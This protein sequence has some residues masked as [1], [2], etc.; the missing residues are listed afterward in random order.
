MEHRSSPRIKVELIPSLLLLWFLFIAFALALANENTWQD[1]DVI[2]SSL[3]HARA[4][5]LEILVAIFSCA[6]AYA[7]I[8]FIVGIKRSG[9]CHNPI[10]VLLSPILIILLELVLYVFTIVNF[11]LRL[12]FIWFVFGAWSVPVYLLSIGFMIAIMIVLFSDIKL[13]WKSPRSS[14]KAW[15]QLPPRVTAIFVIMTI[16]I[17]IPVYL[18][19]LFYFPYTYV[20][21]T[22]TVGMFSR[23]ASDVDQYLVAFVTSSC[24][25]MFLAWYTGKFG[26]RGTGRKIT[27]VIG[28]GLVSAIK[29]VLI[30]AMVQEIDTSLQG[31]LPGLSAYSL[32]PFIIIAAI[33]VLLELKSAS[34]LGRLRPSLESRHQHN[35]VT[36]IDR[37]SRNKAFGM[38]LAFIVLAGTFYLAPLVVTPPNVDVQPTFEI[39]NVNG[40]PVPF[41]N[42]V[43]YPN[44]ELQPT[45]ADGGSR[46]YINL[47][48]NWR[49]S[50]SAGASD[51][52]FY[53]RTTSTV[54]RLG[55]GFESLAF[56]DSA[57][58]EMAVPSSFNRLDNPI[59][60][61]RGVQGVCWYRDWFNS[62]LLQPGFENQTVMLKCLGSNYFTDAWVDGHYAGFHEGGFTSFALDITSLLDANLTR[63]LLAIRVDSIGFKTASYF[64]KVVPGFADWFNYAGIVR[65]IYIEITPRVHVARADIRA[66]SIQPH[67]GSTH[68]ARA[69]IVVNVSAEMS[70]IIPSVN[71][72]LALHQLSFPNATVVMDERTWRHVNSS[73]PGPVITTGSTTTILTAS[74]LKSEEFAACSIAFQ[75][76]N[77]SLWT[78]KQPNLYA[79]DINLSRPGAHGII[80]RFVTQVGFRN[81]T[82][83]GSRFLLNGV[84]IFLAGASIH[85]EWA[86]SGRTLTPAQIFTDLSNMKNLSCDIFRSHYPMSPRCYLY[87]DR[88]GLSAWQECPDYWFNEVNFIEA[89]IRGSTKAMFLEM[90]YRD[91]NR[92]SIF[93]QGITNEPIS[94]RLQA[95]YALERK[96]LLASI[97]SSRIL[98]FA[99]ASPYI[100]TS[101]VTD[102]VGYNCYWG[103][104]EGVLGDYY[105]QARYAISSV[106]NSNPGK[107]IVITEFGAGN[108]K[109]NKSSTTFQEYCRAFEDNHAIC[110]MLYWVYADYVG[111]SGNVGTSGV[112]SWDRTSQRPTGLVMHE[113]YSNLTSSNP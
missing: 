9:V 81:F 92:P 35:I 64:D 38:S 79:L 33:L 23:Y 67:S 88:M 30:G 89:D 77:L 18:E 1:L 80:D 51:E 50:F 107:P 73:I 68:V 43:V 25:F 83:D 14:R 56:D 41:E 16:A 40:I 6:T 42:G 8:I 3:F 86:G 29:V 36:L 45:M 32:Y 39:R 110:G 46:S 7:V 13:L 47:T 96:A 99:V 28:F 48:G 105:N 97:D 53:P 34:I 101:V 87:A 111:Y 91:F 85:E 106:A 54:T 63:H 104:E 94:E 27:L 75:V 55:A 24:G 60:A 26:A 65:D 112:Y 108:N 17:A 37:A 57:W 102:I 52:S 78:N 5:Y 19:I 12:D 10:N 69:G 58:M 4:P 31:A 72:T 98:G 49:F 93:F 20:F 71:I 59:E 66:T 90:V 70:S 22:N 113:I 95:S 62:S 100:T 15:L 103:I 61:F 109:N 82:I 11:R 76:D 84:P 74:G 2:A 44:F 21:W